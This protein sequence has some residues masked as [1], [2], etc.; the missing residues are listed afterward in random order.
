V[1]EESIDPGEI[2]REQRTEMERVTREEAWFLGEQLD[3]FVH[4]HEWD[5]Q[6]RVADIWLKNGQVFREQAIQR[7]RNREPR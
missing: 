7:I 2:I 1:D 6:L 3:R 4:Q 5:V